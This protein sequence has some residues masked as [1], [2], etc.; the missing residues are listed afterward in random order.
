MESANEAPEVSEASEAD[1]RERLLSALGNQGVQRL[2]RGGGARE[3]APAVQRQGY[4]P[5]PE[6]EESEEE[7]EA[8]MAEA[9]PDTEEEAA[10]EADIYELS[11]EVISSGP[12]VEAL[13]AGAQGDL[14][15]GEAAAVPGALE[16]VESAS[17]EAESMKPEVEGF[18][19]PLLL[20]RHRA[21]R[22]SLLLDMTGIRPH[23]GE[24]VALDRIASHVANVS[25]AFAG[26]FTAA[27]AEKGGGEAGLEGAEGGEAEPVAI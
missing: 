3:P 6:G 19:D 18:A 8:E 25:S 27:A 9:L 14:E 24:A 20:A 17:E 26:Q 4:A 23:V 12:V 15:T 2:L 16:K 11:P 5:G 13:V 7:A 21:L 1:G 10:P 22:Q